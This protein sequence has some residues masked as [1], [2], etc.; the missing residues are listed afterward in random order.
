MTAGTAPVRVL[1]VDDE[2]A[3]LRFLRVGLGSQG[4]LVIEA[5]NAESALDVIRQCR[6]D[7]LMLDLGL[8]DMDGLDVIRRIRDGGSML[9]IIVLSSRNDEAAKVQALDFGADDYV[10]KPFGVDEVAGAGQGSTAASSA[11][12]R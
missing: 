10:T 4:Y 9:P 11:T 1:V 5:G 12:A 2:P 8:P 3:I 6:A 7:L